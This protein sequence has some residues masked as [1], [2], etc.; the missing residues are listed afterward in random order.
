MSA[1]PTTPAVPSVEPGQIYRNTKK[2]A[3]YEIV[4]LATHS[5]DDSDMVVYRDLST[6]RNFVRPLTLFVGTREVDGVEVPRFILEN[7]D[8]SG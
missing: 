4:C 2:N 7:S 6:A 5:E 8:G 1:D 3:R